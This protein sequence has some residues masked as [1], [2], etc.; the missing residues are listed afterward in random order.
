[1][2]RD[3]KRAASPESRRGYSPDQN[4]LESKSHGNRGHRNEREMAS[5]HHSDNRSHGVR[6]RDEREMDHGHR[7]PRHG[8]EQAPSV[9]E[10]YDCQLKICSLLYKFVQKLVG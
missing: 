3:R 5:S 8:E 10:R 9:F 6:D 7:H 1:M 4:G 2:K